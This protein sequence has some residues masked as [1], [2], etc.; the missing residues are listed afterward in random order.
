MDLN[1]ICR[2]CVMWYY[3]L[4]C[5]KVLWIILSYTLLGTFNLFVKITKCVS[6]FYKPKESDTIRE[7]IYF[8]TEN[9]DHIITL[10]QIIF[11]YTVKTVF[12]AVL[13]ITVTRTK[14]L[15]NIA[16]VFIVLCF[17]QRKHLPLFHSFNPLQSS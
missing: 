7:A 13:T 12:L 3:H 8:E 17:R 4:H 11:L 10:S 1:Y 14:C 9:I 16:I 2:K 15:A 6:V 5:A